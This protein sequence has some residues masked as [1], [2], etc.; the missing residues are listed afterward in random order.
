MFLLMFLVF[1]LVFLALTG[2]AS[3]FIFSEH[4]RERLLAVA[5]A[6]L[7]GLFFL[8]GNSFVIVPAGEARVAMV[9]G[10]VQDDKIFEEGA[11]FWVNPFYSYARYNVRRQSL[12]FRDAE[13]L[14]NLTSDG[15]NL[16]LD[17]SVPWRLNPQR[18]DRF[19]RVIGGN[20]ANRMLAP[21]VRSSVRDAV[22]GFSWTEAGFT[23]REALAQ[24]VEAAI[25]EG[26]RTDLLRSGFSEP[27]AQTVIEV[28]QVQTRQIL[29]PQRIIDAVSEKM[30]AEE[31]LARQKTLT[32][33]AEEEAR[34]RAQEGR[35]VAMLFD[36]LPDG[37]STTD[38]KI[39]LD[40]VST[41]TR[42]DAI[43]KAVDTGQVKNL[44]LFGDSA[45]P[46]N[47]AVPLPQ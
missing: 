20:Y 27:E 31:D 39:I 13:R 8:I 14:T 1:V 33:I 45:A 23:D 6:F 42:A 2:V 4:P 46:A 11:H 28:Y 15:V 21:V 29:P 5:G 36:E 22:A 12:D 30:A 10:V 16:T 7:A 37:F 3:W 17:I 19:H 24:A 47:A 44:V 9:F 38:I 41:K 35:G 40:A 32:Q 34:R 25:Q 26:L 18:L 43:Q